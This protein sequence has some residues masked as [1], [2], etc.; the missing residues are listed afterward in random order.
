MSLPATKLTKTLQNHAERCHLCFIPLKKNC[1]KRSFSSIYF[2]VLL[3]GSPPLM[4]WIPFFI[5]LDR[6]RLLFRTIWCL[7]FRSRT[8]IE[9]LTQFPKKLPAPPY[10][11]IHSSFP[12]FDTFFLKLRQS[13]NFCPRSKKKVSNCSEDQSPSIQIPKI[14]VSTTLGGGS[15]SI[16]I[17]TIF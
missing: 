11:Q 3:G 10:F 8:K 14:L 16:F 6:R 15:P 9:R 13:L 17:S 2:P 1:K 5:Y 4:W 7:L 12:P